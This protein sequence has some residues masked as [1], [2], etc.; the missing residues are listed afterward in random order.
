MARPDLQQL[1]SSP[2]IL[3]MVLSY[4]RSATSATSAT[5]AVP[6]G[7]GPLNRWRLY[8]RRARKWYSHTRY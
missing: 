5:S 3:S 6:Q 8:H 7:A 4:I 1:A 2:L